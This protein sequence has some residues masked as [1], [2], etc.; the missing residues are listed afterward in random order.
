[1]DLR[2]REEADEGNDDQIQRAVGKPFLD[3]VLVLLLLAVPGGA[4]L[5][6]DAASPQRGL[7]GLSAGSRVLC[8]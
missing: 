8:N 3:R 6:G 4:S 1:V 7:P 5:A 2:L